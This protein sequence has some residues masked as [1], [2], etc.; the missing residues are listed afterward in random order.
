M[1]IATP[2]TLIALLRAVAFG[3]RQERLAENAKEISDLGKELYKRLTNMSDS[4]RAVGKGLNAATNAY[5]KAVGSL[6]ARVLV[7]ARKFKDLDAVGVD[8]EIEPLAPV[9]TTP[10]RL[11]APELLPPDPAEEPPKESPERRISR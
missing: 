2:T 8:A 9:E 6:E 3:W 4:V 11:Q 7:T 10:R 5:N 1:I